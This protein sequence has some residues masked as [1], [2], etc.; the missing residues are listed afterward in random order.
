M[1]E[2][3]RYLGEHYFPKA[4][5]FKFAKFPEGID[6]PYTDDELFQMIREAKEADLIAPITTGRNGR[7][8]WDRKTAEDVLF[9]ALTKK[10]QKRVK[11][12]TINQ[13]NQSDDKN[14][15]ARAKNYR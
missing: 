2:L 10:G 13:S 4:V 7:W 12:N 1:N 15:R 6:I 8:G 3:V 9:V 11:Q 14:V 5:A